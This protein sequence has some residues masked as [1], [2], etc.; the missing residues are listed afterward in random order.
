MPPRYQHSIGTCLHGASN[1]MPSKVPPRC[2]TRCPTICLQ[3]FPCTVP[4]K[5][6]KLSA[7]CTQRCLQGTSRDVQGT[8]GACKL[9]V[10]LVRYTCKKVPCKAVVDKAAAPPASAGRSHPNDNLFQRNVSLCCWQV[11]HAHESRVVVAG[12]RAGFLKCVRFPGV[13]VFWYSWQSCQGIY[14]KGGSEN[15]SCCAR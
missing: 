2:L 3:D 12:K 6:T 4:A 10:T 5:C 15:I 8:L 11:Q 7:R 14:I 9:P 1:N 13:L